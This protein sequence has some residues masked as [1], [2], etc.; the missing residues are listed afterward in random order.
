VFVDE[1]TRTV[2][3]W[4]DD[5]DWLSHQ[6]FWDLLWPGWTL[7]HEDRGTRGHIERSGRPLAAIR[8]PLDDQRQQLAEAL[9]RLLD[10]ASVP[11]AMLAREAARLLADHPDATS[12]V[13]TAPPRPDTSG[14]HEILSG[15][16][17][18]LD[19]LIQRVDGF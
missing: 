10:R 9:A 3:W 15:L 12:C 16:S 17:P 19:A 8:L 6:S 4:Q 14:E 1:A 5:P 7:A 13:E 18:Q 2:H 11:R